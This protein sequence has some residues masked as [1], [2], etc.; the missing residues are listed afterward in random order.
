MTSVDPYSGES[1]FGCRFEIAELVRVLLDLLLEDSKAKFVVRRVQIYDQ[2]G[3]PALYLPSLDATFAWRSLLLLELR[4]NSIELRGLSL[5]ARRAQDG[6]FYIGGI[7]I[8]PADPKGGFSD[9][10][11]QQRRIHI[12]DAA[13]IWHD[14]TWVI[15]YYMLSSGF[16]APAAAELLLHAVKDK[17]PGSRMAVLVGV[18]LQSAGRPADAPRGAGV[19]HELAEAVAA[20]Y[21]PSHEAIPGLVDRLRAEVGP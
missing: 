19:P 10:V 8:N 21:A 18:S 1:H 15:A 20:Y 16:D 2:K 3:Q 11:L 5:N 14:D 13:L 7:A 12:A 6:R 17:I 9:W 4:F